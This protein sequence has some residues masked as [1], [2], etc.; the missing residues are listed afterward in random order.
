M[1]P[2]AK[3]TQ[4][5]GA[6]QPPAGYAEALD[7]IEEILASLEEADVD[8][9]VLATRVQRAAQLIAFCRERIGNAR[10]QIEKAVTDLGD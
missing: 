10:L 7:E 9:D 4:S 8:V 3:G 6:G 5:S 2:S 1:S